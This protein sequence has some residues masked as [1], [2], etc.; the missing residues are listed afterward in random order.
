MPVRSMTGFGAAAQTWESPDGPTAIT[1]EARSV[2]GRHLEVRVRSPWG[3]GVEQLVR[4]HV[5][6]RCGRGR[7]DVAIA[8][9]RAA[10]GVTAE[11]DALG[12]V[13][14]DR[15]RIAAAIDACVEAT[16]MA[17]RAGLEVLPVNILELIRN[18]TAVRAGSEAASPGPPDV[19][20]PLV[21]QAVEAMLAFRETEGAA[22]GEVLRRAVN[23]LR[24]D[25]DRV[26]L[27][28]RDQA[29]PVTARLARRVRELCEAAGTAPPDESRLVQE[30]AIVAMRGDI[31]EEIAR[32]GLHLTRMLE[33]L[34]AAATPGQGRTLEFVA[35][36]VLREL[37][38][39]G[40]KIID[41]EG[42]QLV[43]DAKGTLERVREQVSNVE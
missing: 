3:I 43:I 31:A 16:A 8:L 36:E 5:E 42:A 30:L 29:R 13:G 19:L 15:Q 22:L 27:L 6:A 4:R 9:G 39:V 2:N 23:S 18:S 10:E 20:E 32:L 25:V 7:V 21:V 28:A 38:T 12:R 14:V 34:D 24:G 41:G 37:T 11:V 26:E 35:Q 33:V 1:V 17:R 40:S